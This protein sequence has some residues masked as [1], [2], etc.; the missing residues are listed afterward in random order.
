M[1]TKKLSLTSKLNESTKAHLKDSEAK[2][3]KQSNEV[4]G[5]VIRKNNER[6]AKLGK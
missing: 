4:H 3:L 1:K 6:L 5:E 2:S